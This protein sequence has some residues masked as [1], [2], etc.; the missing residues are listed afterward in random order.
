MTS[1]VTL[2]AELHAHDM[3]D[4]PVMKQLIDLASETGEYTGRSQ[5]HHCALKVFNT[6]ARPKRRIA[7]IPNPWL[8][9]A[10]AFLEDVGIKTEHLR[11]SRYA[12]SGA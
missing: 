7:E 6:Y 1:D 10:V 11:S 4:V 8:T 12:G 9:Q 5:C 3:L 2:W